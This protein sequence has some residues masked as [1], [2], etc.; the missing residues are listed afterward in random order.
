MSDNYVASGSPDDQGL[1]QST[2]TDD[3]Q[4][5]YT[6]IIIMILMIS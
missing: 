3:G 6:M 5:W 1:L 2:A 4:S